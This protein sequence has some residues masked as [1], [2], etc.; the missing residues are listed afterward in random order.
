M[1]VNIVTVNISGGDMDAIILCKRAL[2]DKCFTSELH[3]MEQKLIRPQLKNT[4][5]PP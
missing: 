5:P 3:I 1:N 2:F 4:S